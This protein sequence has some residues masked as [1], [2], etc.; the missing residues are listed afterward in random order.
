[1]DGETVVIVIQEGRDLAASEQF[2]MLVSTDGAA[3]WMSSVQPVPM[4]PCRSGVELHGMDVLLQC[5]GEDSVLDF[6][7]GQLAGMPAW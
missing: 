2:W 3:T 5:V 4:P 7:R 6:R 1:M